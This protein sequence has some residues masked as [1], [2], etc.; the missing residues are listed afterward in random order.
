VKSVTLAYLQ[1]V[2]K[3]GDGIELIIFALSFHS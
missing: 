2:D 3:N 1:L